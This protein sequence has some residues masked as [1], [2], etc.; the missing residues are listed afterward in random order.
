MTDPTPTIVI[1]DDE[2]PLEDVL[3]AADGHIREI[4]T[5]LEDDPYGSDAARAGMKDAGYAYR[6]AIYRELGLNDR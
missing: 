4:T 3:D 1:G 6:K 2:Y 5:S